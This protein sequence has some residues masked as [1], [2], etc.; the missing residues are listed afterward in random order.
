MFA[1]LM[2]LWTGCGMTQRPAR[3]QSGESIT[4]HIHA[5]THL[6][7]DRAGFARSV[8]LRVYQLGD[9]RGFHARSFESVWAEPISEQA[10][11]QSEQLTA[12]P[13][14]GQAFALRR[15]PKAT[16][17]AVAAHFR[18]RRGPSSWRALV[19]LPEPRGPCVQWP[20]ERNAPIELRLAD[21][22]LQLR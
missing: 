16:H 17:L 19:R 2:L 14:R 20:Q 21:Y 22:N 11:A 12:I 7:P 8:V 3:C 18:E 15:D 6:N 9:V 10:P 1:A 5:A 13:G 4:L